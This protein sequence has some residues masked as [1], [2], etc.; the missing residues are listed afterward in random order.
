MKPESSFSHKKKRWLIAVLV[1]CYL[2]I[3][4][5]GCYR[6]NRRALRGDPIWP[7]L[8]E[9]TQVPPF[10]FRDPSCS[11]QFIY[12]I[13]LWDIQCVL[14]FPHSKPSYLGWSLYVGLFLTNVSWKSPNF[15]KS[16]VSL[17]YI[18]IILKEMMKKTYDFPIPFT[19]AW[20]QFEAPNPI[21]G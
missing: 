11:G 19:T 8:L 20:A 6:T 2:S 16:Y 12:W 17:N 15:N 7:G 10:A 18:R 1:G 14:W 5:S 13:K 3:L 9:P 4:T 21:T